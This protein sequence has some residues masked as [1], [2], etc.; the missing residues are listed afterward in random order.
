MLDQERSG[1]L[2]PLKPFFL[3]YCRRRYQQATAYEKPLEIIHH[4][5]LLSLRAIVD[6][7]LPGLRAFAPDENSHHCHFDYK[8]DPML[9]IAD[10]YVA[11]NNPG[12]IQHDSDKEDISLPPDCGRP[13]SQESIP[14]AGRVLRDV[15]S[16]TKLNEA[17]VDDP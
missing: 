9:K 2:D 16:Y 10:C 15:T 12:D 1:P 3:M 11:S 8:F 5:I 17:M 7:I 14:G 6:T 13:S 4:D